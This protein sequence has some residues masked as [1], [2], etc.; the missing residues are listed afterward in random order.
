[1]LDDFKQKLEEAT[2]DVK[3]HILSGELD[4][5]TPPETVNK[6]AAIFNVDAAIVPNSYHFAEVAKPG[7]LNVHLKKLLKQVLK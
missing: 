3:I 7:E 6:L 4:E 5:I 2:L 1:M